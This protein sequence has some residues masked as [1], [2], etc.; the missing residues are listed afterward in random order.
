MS[1]ASAV[2]ECERR[3]WYAR[4][5]DGRWTTC[6]ADDEGALPDINRLAFLCLTGEDALYS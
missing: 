3:G 6:D 4:Q 5:I 1:A 2:T